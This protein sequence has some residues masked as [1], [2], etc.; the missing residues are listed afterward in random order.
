MEI[1]YYNFCPSCGK[2]PKHVSDCFECDCGARY[3]ITCLDDYSEADAAQWRRNNRVEKEYYR[4]AIV[5]GNGIYEKCRDC[6]QMVKINKFLFGD[7]HFC[8]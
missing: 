4:N 7:L 2:R 8:N 5:A 6:G 3:K 1:N